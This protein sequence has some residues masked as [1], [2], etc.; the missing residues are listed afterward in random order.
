MAAEQP[1]GASSCSGC[2]AVSARTKTS[3]PRILGRS[4][5][6][7]AAA[8]ADFRTAKRASTVMDRIAKGFNESETQAIATW[9]AA[10]K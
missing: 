1:P 5:A 2:H 8:M 9:L 6:D 3:V 10:Q 7:I 4:A